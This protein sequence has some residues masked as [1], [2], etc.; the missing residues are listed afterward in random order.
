M[1]TAYEGVQLILEVIGTEAQLL[2]W[3]PVLTEFHVQWKALSTHH[4][5][6]TVR[7]EWVAMIAQ[8]TCIGN[9]SCPGFLEVIMGWTEDKDFGMSQEEK[10][11]HAEEVTLGNKLPGNEQQW[12]L[13]S[14][15]KTSEMESSCMESPMAKCRNCRRT[16][17]IKSVCRGKSHPAGL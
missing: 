9:P 7:R 6:N 16:R 4:T 1:L 11:L 17:W 5:T 13:L 3:L 15:G 10:V 12:M 14:H 2:R 8:Q